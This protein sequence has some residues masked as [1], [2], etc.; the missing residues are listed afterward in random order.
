MGDFNAHSPLWY[1]QKLEN[2]G[3]Q[4]ENLIN[5]AD[6]ITLNDNQATSNIDL[7]LISN[8]I[9]MDFP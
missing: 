4:I 3:S 7:A 8:L 5:N 2:R 1:D 6:L 9:A